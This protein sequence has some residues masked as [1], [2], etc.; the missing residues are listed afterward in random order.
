MRTLFVILA[1]FILLCTA[2]CSGSAKPTPRPAPDNSDS[3]STGPALSYVRASESSTPEVTAELNGVP[4][5][6]LWDTGA[7]GSTIS[8][9]EKLNLVKAG[10]L[11]EDD[12]IGNMR[13]SIA[14]GS[15]IIVPVY[16]IRQLTLKT[17]DGKELMVNNVTVSI[18]DNPEAEA[19]LGQNVMKELPKYTFDD[20]E[21]VIRFEQ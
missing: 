17:T 5:K 13:V 18:V 19:L 2:G 10:K 1:S 20:D 4:I 9:L 15:I 3:V 11:S 8:T 21:S 14:D 6:M 7:T 12:K 16:V